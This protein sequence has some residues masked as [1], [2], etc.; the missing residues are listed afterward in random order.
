[1]HLLKTTLAVAALM[2]GPALAQAEMSDAER[3]A[4]R[5]EVRAYLLENP[6][7]LMEAIG[8]LEAREA[9]AAAEAEQAALVAV[10]DQLLND[11]VS[12]E[13]GNPDG[14]I[15]VVEFLDYRCGY[16]KRAF[17]DVERLIAT[18]GN[19]KIIIKEFP[20]LGDASVLASRFALATKMEAGDQAYK[21]V[22]D[23]LMEFRGDVTEA[24]LQRIAEGLALDPTVIMARMND[25]EISRIIQNN[26]ALG[27]ALQI[28]GTPSF[29]IADEIIR[30]YIP[31]DR[32]TAL[33]DELRG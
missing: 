18:D 20:I 24:S 17:P 11:G 15:T 16:C 7:V 28:N 21:D 26:R 32:M 33:V 14:D 23:T 5:D 8:V 12:W 1:M 19:V 22:H 30:G 25:P 13:G 27:E 9:A 31:Y 4:F 6:E 10:Q 3:Q 29:I 2:T